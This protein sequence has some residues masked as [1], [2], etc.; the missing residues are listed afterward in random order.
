MDEKASLF[1]I[2]VSW[3]LLGLLLSIGWSLGAYL[4]GWLAPLAGEKMREMKTEFYE[5]R[6][7]K[8]EVKKA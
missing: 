5:A 3:F 4:V 7:A 1:S 2:L 8:A 6:R